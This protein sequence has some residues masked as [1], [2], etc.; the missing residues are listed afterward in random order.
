MGG[1]DSGS[2]AGASEGNHGGRRH[3]RG[4]RR[5]GGHPLRGHQGEAGAG[6]A[7]TLWGG[8]MVRDPQPGDRNR[9][10]LLHN[11]FGEEDWLRKKCRVCS[12][13]LD[14]GGH[15]V[16][17]VVAP[18]LNPFKVIQKKRPIHECTQL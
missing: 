14:T 15:F 7:S 16:R 13:R 6:P 2:L 4:P 11:D 1:R 5:A 12:I 3:P 17:A 9:H 8:Q 10:L 18:R